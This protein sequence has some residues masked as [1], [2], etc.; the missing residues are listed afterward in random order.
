MGSASPPRRE[1]LVRY[2]V[3]HARD[4]SPMVWEN[5]FVFTTAR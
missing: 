1:R 5:T 2:A 4:P 3:I